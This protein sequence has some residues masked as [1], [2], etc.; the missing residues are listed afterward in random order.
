MVLLTAVTTADQVHKN[1]C[2]VYV[3]N[4]DHHFAGGVTPAAFRIRSDNG[5]REVFI[6]GG[7]RLSAHGPWVDDGVEGNHG[8]RF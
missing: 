2:P 8:K 1:G 4:Q 5:G 6:H 7:M 3:S